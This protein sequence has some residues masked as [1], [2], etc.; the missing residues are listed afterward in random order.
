MI[1]H[2][3]FF[4]NNKKMKENKI[5]FYYIE[6]Y[7]AWVENHLHMSSSESRKLL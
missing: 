5:Q 4:Q 2:R 3:S 7:D 6:S 1:L